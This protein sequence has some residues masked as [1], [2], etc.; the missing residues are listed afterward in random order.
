MYPSQA[1]ELVNQVWQSLPGQF[2]QLDLDTFQV[3]PNHFHAILE[4]RHLP[5]LPKVILGQ[6]VGAFKS[7]VTRHYCELV[8]RHGWPRFRK[9][10]WQRGSYDHVIRND[11]AY[12]RIANY[13]HDNP[14]R[15]QFDRLNPE[16][17]SQVRAGTRTGPYAPTPPSV[18]GATLV[19]ARH[20]A[21][22]S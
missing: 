16:Q 1:G 4:I 19:V 11:R 9:A 17:F 8:R 6:I 18:V 20:P 21:L 22:A 14:V 10:F 7:E 5:N 15:W 3:M 13:I 2:L 12:Q